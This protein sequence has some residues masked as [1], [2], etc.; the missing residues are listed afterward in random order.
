[1]ALP[2]R[3]LEKPSL[4]QVCRLAD[5]LTPVEQEQLCYSLSGKLRRI[6]IAGSVPTSKN[7]KL[8]K[9]RKDAQAALKR[10]GVTVEEL[11]TE[12]KNVR[13]DNFAKKYPDLANAP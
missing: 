6:I 3:K 1:M 12:A 8:D 4:K 7:Q 5:Q 13:E 10:A 9:I 2:K 11:L